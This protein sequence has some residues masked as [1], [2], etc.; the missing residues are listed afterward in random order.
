MGGSKQFGFVCLVLGA[1]ACGSSAPPPATEAPDVDAAAPVGGTGGSKAPPV[2]D[3]N[4]LEAAG[5]GGAD[6]APAPPPGEDT[7]A[8]PPPGE[9]AAPPPPDSSP[10]SA[11]PPLGPFPLEAVKAARPT[12][13]VSAA[14][15]LEGP[16]W[17]NG[18]L[19]FAADGGGYGLMRVDAAGKLYRYQPKLTPIGT[20]ALADGSLLACD[21]TYFL[22]QVFADGKVGVIGSDFQGKPIGE[23][24]CNDVAVDGD[25]NIFVS[26]RRSGAIYR[27]SP[28]GDVIKV[29]DGKDGPNGVE[30]DPANRFLYFTTGQG[31]AGRVWRMALPTA[32]GTTFGPVEMVAAAGQPDG[33]AFDAWGNLWVAGWSGGQVY[34]FAPDNKLITTITMSGPI[35][36]TFGGSAGDTLFIE[37]DNKGVYKLGP[38]PGLRGFMHPGAARYQI[39]QM[40]ALVPANEPVR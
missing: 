9:D 18:E 4:P 6:A 16:S 23:A 14:T 1:L 40:L 13:Y 37:E 25:G 8:M 7:A 21:H 39:K 36:L 5:T 17:H 12:L 11:G 33:L 34:I 19:F 15:H 30:V 26:A 28:A 32:G 3:A 35:N 20:Y 31:G 27:I 10:D 38:V 2:A 24:F 29:T 22:V